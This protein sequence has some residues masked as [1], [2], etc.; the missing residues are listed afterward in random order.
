MHGWSGWISV[1][2]K[3]QTRIL[4]AM[5]EWKRLADR[6]EFGTVECF[7]IPSVFE[8]VELERGWTQIS[9]LTDWDVL[10]LQ[11]CFRKLDGVSVGAHKLL[12]PCELLG[13]LR[14]PAVIVNQIRSGQSKAVGGASRGT[15]VELD[16]Q[17]T[18]I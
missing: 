11:E 7:D 5:F 2:V 4:Q 3:G 8:S 9:M 15:A 10:L 16:G 12:T 1:V 6:K 17:M 13:G 18:F 14:C